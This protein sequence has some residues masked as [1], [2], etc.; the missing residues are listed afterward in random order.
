MSRGGNEM[1]RYWKVLSAVVL[2]MALAA[3]LMSCGTGG[4]GGT[5]ILLPGNNA[6]KADAG[7]NRNILI[8]SLVTLDGSGSSDIEGDAITY[9]W[10]F[11][12]TP[13]GS[14]A[15]LSNATS[16]LPQFFAD[17][18]GNYVV[19]LIVNDGMAD[20]FPDS[21]NITATT[22]T[23]N[24]APVVDAGPDQNVKTNTL[25]TLNGS[26]S[27]D[28]DGNPITYSWS[29]TTAP[30]GSN[31]TLSSSTAVNP[32]FTAD[33]DGSYIVQLV[34][35]DGTVDSAADSVTITAATS[36]S[37]P[38]ADAGTYQS[39]ALDTLVTL[40]GSGSSDA[41]GDPLTYSWSFTTV[42]GGS[43]AT[44]SSSTAVNPT[45]T[46]DLDG[47]YVVHLIVN[48]G[49]V[50]STADSV[51][52]T[53]SRWTATSITDAPAGRYYHTAVWTG[54]KMIV[55]GGGAGSTRFNT[56]GIYDPAANLWSATSTT[57]APSERV[58]HTAV[59]TGSKMIVWG[60]WDGASH[61]NTGGIY[62]PE[63]DTWTA[64]ST[65]GAPTGRY[66]HTAIWTGTKMIV[67]GGVDDAS[68]PNAGRTYDPE[69]N[70]WT[71][72]STLG[73]PTGR[74]EHTAVWTGTEMIIWGG[75]TGAE[76][77]NTGGKYDPAT[78]TWTTISAT[79]APSGRLLHT[80]VW[81]GT[82]MIVWGGWDGTS[83]FNTGG[84]YDPAMNIWT[85]TS[86]TVAP[87]E[88]FYHTAVWTDSKMIVW[89]GVDGSYS[90]TGGIYDP[91]A[92]AWTATGTVGA[93][94]G[95]YEHTAVWT[96]TEMIVWG[97]G[98]YNYSGTGGVYTP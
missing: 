14:I 87:T 94:I 38:V 75:A 83:R 57:S 95:K 31:A 1:K 50:D 86:T 7:P 15:T 8:G 33:V 84:T 71:A 6:P 45:F 92:D 66:Y 47:Y 27:Y 80:A 22:A 97:G 18:E 26:W 74:Y 85:A 25:V 63:A 77:L 72:M 23:V 16:V 93:P 11:T 51:T 40:D 30:E 64:T 35:N 53:A 73:A 9:R 67:W 41:D 28:P 79:D 36:N 82:K 52:I 13:D 61:L 12:M 96:D 78:N 37:A 2:N 20:S 44:L 5:T 21:V 60:G 69:T 70:E 55:W 43:N 65:T 62:D 19:Q 10:S 68:Y 58:L 42:P 90:N 81:T 46:A 39:V 56:G 24:S 89:G 29:L 4:N 34:V 17:L 98:I 48:D 49:T 91:V 59:W 54:T 32:T 76:A 88:R 3:G